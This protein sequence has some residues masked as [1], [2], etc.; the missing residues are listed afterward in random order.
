MLRVHRHS[1]D[2]CPKVFEGVVSMALSRFV[3]WGA[4]CVVALGAAACVDGAGN[5][6]TPTP[7]EVGP[8][9]NPDGTLLKANAPS[10]LSPSG[11]TRIST[12][13][14]QLSI[15]NA[16]YT[17]GGPT[18]S[19]EFEIYEGS[20]L[21]LGSGSIVT[22]GDQTTWTV[23]ANTLRRNRSYLWRA[24][25]MFAD[26][27]GSWSDMATFRTPLPVDGPVPC[28]G[29]SGLDIIR[30]V[31]AA[32]P[33]RLVPTARGDFSLERRKA[34]MNFIRDRIIET[35]RCK[36]LDLARNFKRGTPVISHD[37][38]VWRTGGRNRGVDIARGFDD[39]N[40][41]LRLSWQV[42]GP[43]TYGHPFYARYPSVDCSEVNN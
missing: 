28:R 19:H 16:S 36:G 14:P 10:P 24:R 22:A 21:V 5:T 7:P 39:V 42:F 13:T 15:A 40:Q 25:A 2:G 18:L 8:T 23:P 30:C 29:S 38:I 34:N 20:T 35:G 31:A 33:S 4:V 32:Y 26:V 17:Y 1:A 43:P 37:F 9:A 3:A 12:L 11:N 6:L 27:T 41:P